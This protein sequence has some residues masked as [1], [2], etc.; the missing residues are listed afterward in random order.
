MYQYIITK[1]I[2][3]NRRYGDLSGDSAFYLRLQDL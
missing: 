3:I 2:D 1:G